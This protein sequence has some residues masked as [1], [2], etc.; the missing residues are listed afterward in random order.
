MTESRQLPE[1]TKTID[2][3]AKCLYLQSSPDGDWSSLWGEARLDWIDR[4]RQVLRT[5][6]LYIKTKNQDPNLGPKSTKQ[7]LRLRKHDFI[8]AVRIK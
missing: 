4:A 1:V 3:V 2:Q 5:S 6:N 7:L 8:R